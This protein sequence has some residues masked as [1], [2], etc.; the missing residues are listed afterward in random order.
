MKARA[1]VFVVALVGLA[2]AATTFTQSPATPPREQAPSGQ[3]E[4]L[5]TKTEA[6]TYQKR[7]ERIRARAKKIANLAADERAAQAKTLAQDARAVHDAVLKEAELRI[8]SRQN[9]IGAGRFAKEGRKECI[10]S[11]ESIYSQCQNKAQD[12]YEQYLC[13]VDAATCVLGCAISP[14]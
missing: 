12:A 8:S 4:A 2:A 3:Q 11:C 1:A 14:Q 9:Q 13:Q 7:L 10:Q 6:A 5:L